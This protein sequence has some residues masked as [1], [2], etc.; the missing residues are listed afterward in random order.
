M[1]RPMYSAGFTLIELMV[2]VLVLSVLLSLA[3]PSFTKNIREG[4]IVSTSEELQSALQLTRSEA[5]M[6]HG[7]VIVCRRNSAGDA[8]ENGT[9]WSAGWLIQQ[10]GGD[11]IKIW[12]ST[13]DVA[14]TGPNAG[15][16]Y[17]SNGMVTAASDFSVTQSSC[18]DSQKRTIS[19]TLNGLSR[20]AKAA[21][22]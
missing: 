19:V 15:V 11:V 18:S 21:C 16:T 2:T 3:V 12:Q 14:I 8:C 9:D 5:I 22:Q 4:K 10:S 1:S 7:D 17:K 6:R 13:P 20:I